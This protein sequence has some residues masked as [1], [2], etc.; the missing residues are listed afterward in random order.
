MIRIGMVGDVNFSNLFSNKES[1][2]FIDNI[3]IDELMKNN[4]N[5][6]NIEG[7]L[8]F[9]NAIPKKGTSLISK[10]DKVNILK[11]LNCNIFNLANNHIMDA[12]L[13]GLEET[14]LIAK[15]NNIMW[16]GAGRNLYEASRPLFIRK[17]DV[18]VA[19]FGICHPEGLLATEN[20]P[21]IFAD[22]DLS[23]IQKLITEYR[24]KSNWIIIC[25][26]GG[27]EYTFY[28]SPSRRLKLRKFI[29]MGAD[30]VVSNH[31]HTIQ[32]YE[33]FKKGIIFYSLGNFIFDIPHQRD[34]EGTDQSVIINIK[35]SK[36]NI[37]YEPIFSSYDRDKN[38]INASSCN[39]Y[40]HS[41]SDKTYRK[42][43]NADCY[44]LYMNLYISY[45][46]K[47]LI[48]NP[49]NKL[50]I[51]NKIKILKPYL[52][53]LKIIYTSVRGCMQKNEREKYFGVYKYMALA[54]LAYIKRYIITICNRAQDHDIDKDDIDD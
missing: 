45:K 41:L 46:N 15:R 32:G 29:D 44:R 49:T 14:I 47:K 33:Y 39:K 38:Y 10:P 34:I 9:E 35:I 50:Y 17:N 4:Y 40:F 31:S 36:D 20:T 53:I 3:I 43:W 16:F 24:K 48:N 27:E 1:A 22:K 19:L 2:D 6:F 28:P 21:G 5:I 42:K 8:T 26:H 13:A 30:I 25:Y 54:P 12:G 51:L 7:P 11:D 37:S 23:L 52:V 18:S